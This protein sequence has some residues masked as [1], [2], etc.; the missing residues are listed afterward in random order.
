MMKKMSK[1]I[2]QFSRDVYEALGRDQYFDEAKSW[3]D[4]MYTSVVASRNRYK[5][6]FLACACLVF[7]LVLCVSMLVPAQHLEPLII[8]HYSDGTTSVSPVR[9]RYTPSNQAELESDI[10]RYITSREGYDFESYDRSYKQV[11][12][13]S[14]TDVFSRYRAEQSTAN[15]NSPII[16]LK[17][18]AFM[19][20]DVRNVI[21]MDLESKNTKREKGH[22]NLAE[23]TYEVTTHNLQTGSTSSK[24]Y[25][26]ILS[27]KYTGL[28]DDPALRW[29]NWNGF[30][31][32]K[33]S[34]GQTNIG[35]KM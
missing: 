1:K 19:Q 25:K 12:V 20:V 30:T 16:R 9:G 22:K 13:M 23:I 34:R 21:I 32:T 26:A 24:P 18:K 15:K 4:D 29:L 8:N 31:V 7:L 28:S 5:C 35:R 14:S 33:F 3:A 6:G 11:A 27:W 10:V 17:N 2:K